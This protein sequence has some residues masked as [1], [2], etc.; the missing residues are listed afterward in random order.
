MYKSISMFKACN[1]GPING[2]LLSWAPPIY[3]E[4]KGVWSKP[5]PHRIILT[6]SQVGSCRLNWD[7]YCCFGIH[8]IKK[9]TYMSY[10]LINCVVFLGISGRCPTQ[11]GKNVY[12]TNGE[13]ENVHYHVEL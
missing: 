2:H 8:I 7:I 10:N 1:N 12:N 9:T 6:S 4:V 5:K 3:S 11:R 13:F